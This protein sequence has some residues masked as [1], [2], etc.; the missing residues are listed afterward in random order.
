VVKPNPHIRT[1]TVFDGHADII[2]DALRLY[3]SQAEAAGSVVD[4]DRAEHAGDYISAQL[5]GQRR[6]LARIA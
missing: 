5:A 2:L 6:K 3:A 4:A 1:L